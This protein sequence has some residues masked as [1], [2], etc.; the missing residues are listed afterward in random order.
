MYKVILIISLFISTLTSQNIPTRVNEIMGRGQYRETGTQAWKNIVKNTVLNEGVTI[1]TSRTAFVEIII[2]DIGK[3][4]LQKDCVLVLKRLRRS[5]S[6]KV[7]ILLRVMSGKIRASL[8]VSFP[9][10]FF[11]VETGHGR[12]SVKGTDFI[13]EANR[14]DFL[15]HVI[16]GEVEIN[17]VFNAGEPKKITKGQSSHVTKS[18]SPSDPSPTINQVYQ[19]WNILK[20]KEASTKINSHSDLVLPNDIVEKEKALP[21]PSL[22]VPP[23]NSNTTPVLNN[24]NTKP[25]NNKRQ[26]PD[27]GAIEWSF[28]IKHSLKA[29]YFKDSELGYQNNKFPKKNLHHWLNFVYMPQIQFGPIHLGL[30]LPL[31]LGFRDEFY[32]PKKH[33]NWQE[34]NFQKTDG[35]WF[36][37]LAIKVTSL[38]I[39]IWR[40]EFE[41]GG[42][43]NLTYGSGYILNN[44][45]NLLEFPNTRIN[46]LQ[47]TYLDEFRGLKGT[48]FIG[49]LSQNILTG[50]RFAINPV[51]TFKKTDD[52]KIADRLE[53]GFSLVIEDKPVKDLVS[54]GH[55][56]LYLQD[57]NTDHSL[58]GFSF[59]T[60]L[61]FGKEKLSLSPYLNLGFLKF[62]QEANGVVSKSNFGPGVSFGLKG[63]AS[64]FTY[65]GEVY[66]NT[67]GFLPEY[68]DAYHIYPEK[69]ADKLYKLLTLNKDDSLG[70][71]LGIGLE[72]KDTI[73]FSGSFREFFKKPSFSPVI[74][75]M[76][77]NKLRIEFE[78]KKG[79]V[80]KFYA[81][82][83]YERNNIAGKRFFKEFLDSETLLGAEA[84]IILAG[85]ME[86][87]VRYRVTFGDDGTPAQTFNFDF[88]LNFPEKG[89]K[90][91]PDSKAK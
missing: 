86:L 6:G 71:L 45:N 17:N 62:R 73:V 88:A 12:A 50:F 77:W 83:F 90:D 37:D 58:T 1:R 39:K 26:R 60:M 48:F 87:I 7:E 59:D 49:D 65:R 25:N 35:D 8:D 46:G 38:G 81:S 10:P 14:S 47:F 32:R 23:P 18:T 82:A 66:Y 13:I 74:Y 44:F 78:L 72:L 63:G 43:N 70:W 27:S 19:T 68:F 11:L 61:P 75:H 76:V 69:R 84:H 53:I 24:T 34:Y 55:N 36:K 16:D 30:Y 29:G 33:Y 57:T 40:F 4:Y 15:L 56:L 67:K 21:P 9:Y 22:P 54:T 85:P 5:E 31:Y 79:V 51:M 80:E 20:Q 41:I 28:K 64:L 91:S 3:V 52:K 2:K 42:M 89:S